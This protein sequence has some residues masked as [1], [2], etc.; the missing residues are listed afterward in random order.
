MEVVWI[1]LPFCSH[2]VQGLCPCPWK[3][4]QNSNHEVYFWEWG[5]WVPL[6][7]SFIFYLLGAFT[8]VKLPAR[9][10]NWIL[11]C[12]F[13]VLK[14]SGFVW[15]KAGQHWLLYKVFE[16]SSQIY[17]RCME[18]GFHGTTVL[19]Q[20][21]QHTWMENTHL[22]KDF[23]ER[24]KFLDRL[25]SAKSDKVSSRQSPTPRIRHSFQARIPVSP[26][27]RVSPRYRRCDTGISRNISSDGVCVG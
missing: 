13:H 22:A 7:D 8:S 23:V 15:M 26:Q 9:Q 4:V 18:W 5:H 25:H 3:R 20:H 12:I 10:L 2:L 27:Q 21:R 1:Y 17:P 11:L 16:N 14:G 6:L 19:P 24:G